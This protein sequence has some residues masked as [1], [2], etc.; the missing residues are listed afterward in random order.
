MRLT[1]KTVGLV[2]LTLLCITVFIVGF[3]GIT[4]KYGEIET[5]VAK[6]PEQLYFGSD[7]S[8]PYTVLFQA[9]NGATLSDKDLE[10]AKT[11]MQK[12]LEYLDI[13]T[14]DLQIDFQHKQL[15][16]TMTSSTD[17]SMTWLTARLSVLG[18][19]YA[20]IDD[21]AS[22]GSEYVFSSSEVVFAKT[23]ANQQ[24][25]GYTE[26]VIDIT[27]NGEGR[28][29]LR[30]ASEYLA[31]EYERS[32]EEKAQYLYFYNGQTNVASTSVKSTISDGKVSFS[33]YN[34]DSD[35]VVE[36]GLFLN[37]GVLPAE[38][39]YTFI[40]LTTT[41]IGQS[42]LKLLG[43]ALLAAF[44]AI[45]VFL[46]IR[47]GA[48]GVIGTL[49]MLGTAGVTM[50]FVTGFFVGNG[51]TVTFATLAAFLLVLLLCSETIVRNG[52]AI[53]RLLETNSL[54]KSVAIGMNTA[55]WP[56]LRLYILAGIAAVLMILCKF[57]NAIGLLL[58]SVGMSGTAISE[59]GSFGTVLIAGLFA[60]FLFNILAMWAMMR[61][62]DD[63]APNPVLYGGSKQDV[64]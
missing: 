31:K 10:Q 7:L 30:T 25:M 29:A 64:E 52:S 50:F 55:F 48:T 11:V 35:T 21:G 37:S 6:S 34:L 56:T 61:F 49:C 24:F 47:Y 27:L 18:D 44:A 4:T 19:I 9:K 1:K 63:V 12:R 33:S 58:R 59:I 23:S 17:I 57:D 62:A 40:T 39:D 36:L 28:K 2:L 14:Y 60:A 26:Y 15:L 38:L 13:Q 8:N 45:A 22:A 51:M 16:L 43:I 46:V 41:G 32:N 53:K 3:F 20:R 54:S 5:I 42:T